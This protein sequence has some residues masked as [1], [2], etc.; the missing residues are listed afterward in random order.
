MIESGGIRR[1]APDQQRGNDGRRAIPGPE[2]SPDPPIASRLRSWEGRLSAPRGRK[3]VPVRSR[4]VPNAK[5]RGPAGGTRQRPR[6]DKP[7][8]A[9][10]GAIQAEPLPPPTWNI[11]GTDIPDRSHS[12]EAAIGIDLKEGDA[13]MEKEPPNWDLDKAMLPRV[14]PAFYPGMLNAPLRGGR[15]PRI[16]A[17]YRK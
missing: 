6:A 10:G 4:L 12:E 3:K 11:P 8:R 17:P 16:I 1:T 14:D 13:D 2:E 7:R 5:R 15:R 9:G